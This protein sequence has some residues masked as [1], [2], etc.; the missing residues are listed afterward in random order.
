MIFTL[1]GGAPRLKPQRPK[2]APVEHVSGQQ[3]AA[4]SLSR[5]PFRP[6]AKRKNR[7][8]RPINRSR[9]RPPSPCRRNWARWQGPSIANPV[10][11]APHVRRLAREIGVDIHDVK[12][13]GPG[14]RISEDDVKAH[15][16]ALLASAATAAQAPRGAQFAQPELA[17][18]HQVGKGRARLHPRRAA[19]DRRAS[20]GKRGPPSRTSRRTIKPTSRSS[21]ICAR[22]LLRKRR[23]PAAR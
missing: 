8:C 15:S 11:A 18:L 23:K 20:C 21:S 13:T 5:P 3:G 2:H 16:K 12:G 4:R 19:Q 17:R 14:G 22:A 6:K 1:E 10:P 9:C 7:R